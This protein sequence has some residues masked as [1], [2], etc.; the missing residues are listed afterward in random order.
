MAKQ[1]WQEERE[2][3]VKQVVDKLRSGENFM[4][5]QGIR[6]VGGADRNAVTGKPYRGGNA[7][8]LWFAGLV[9]KDEFQGEP[10]WCTFKQAADRG[11][12]IKKGSKGVKLEYWKMPDEKDIR[13]KNPGLTDEEV[14]QKLKEAFPVCNVFTVFNCSCVEGMPPMP[15]REETNDT[16]PEL[17]AAIDN[18]EAKVLHDQ[19]NRNFYRPA[20]DEIHLMP[21]ELFKSDKFYY[22]TAVHEIA[23]STGA[24]TRLNRQIKNGNNLELYAEEEVVAEFTSMNLCRR[25]GAA[26]G[27][28]HTTNHMAYISSWAEM[29]E[30]DPNKLFQLAGLAAKAEDYI[31]DNYMKGL[32]L[33]KE[34]AYEKK[35]ADLAKIPEQKEAEKAEEKTRPVRVV[36]KRE[37][38]KET[39]KLKR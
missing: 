30:K 21:K 3:F 14:K 13:K 2:A 27:E 20:T 11:W 28:E 9:M 17:Q 10:R 32:N 29:F 6:T 36:R 15:P 4:W 34:A 1:K 16:F 23:H 33:E 5:D 31:V 8:R 38:K 24:E 12:K 35:I 26:M 37:E 39:A 22:G 18:C 19:T 7:I 25:F